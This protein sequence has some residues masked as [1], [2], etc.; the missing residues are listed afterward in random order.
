MVFPTIDWV[1]LGL[2]NKLETIVP[3]G[4]DPPKNSWAFCPFIGFRGREA[5]KEDTAAV[6]LI[7]R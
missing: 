3:L 6:G 2:I 7:T 4:M 5:V 1:E